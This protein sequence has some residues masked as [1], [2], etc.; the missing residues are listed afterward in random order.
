MT[1]PLTQSVK[2]LSEFTP[3]LVF[4][5]NAAGLIRAYQLCRLRP[6]TFARGDPEQSR[7]VAP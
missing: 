3:P 4:C 7:R 6:S 5:K 1:T 2:G